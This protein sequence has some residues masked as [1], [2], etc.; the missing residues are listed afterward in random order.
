MAK[1][2]SKCDLYASYTHVC[3]AR[4]L[5]YT[6]VCL[7]RRMFAPKRARFIG[8]FPCV[9]QRPAF[10][11]QYQRHDRVPPYPSK[12]SGT[13]RAPIKRER[14]SQRF[15]VSL[16]GSTLSYCLLTKISFGFVLPSFPI[17]PLSR[18]PPSQGMCFLN[19]ESERCE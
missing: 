16:P 7:H 3:G 18:R 4:H 17:F 10:S 6:D 13:R 12:T 15:F 9:P 11:N 1:K 14:L 5:L 2:L 8:Q 19:F